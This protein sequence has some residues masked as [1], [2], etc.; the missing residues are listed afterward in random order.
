MRSVIKSWWCDRS[1]AV[2]TSWE[3]AEAVSVEEQRQQQEEVALLAVERQ[4]LQEE[5]QQRRR[6]RQ[7]GAAVV[8]EAHPLGGGMRVAR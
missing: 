5:Q 1:T 3:E 8:A 6:R 2:Q 7:R 4:Q